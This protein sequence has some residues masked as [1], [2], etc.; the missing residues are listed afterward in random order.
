MYLPRARHFQNGLA[1]LCG[2]VLAVDTNGD[3]LSACD[4][5]LMVIADVAGSNGPLHQRPPRRQADPVP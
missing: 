1:N 5:S 2:D 3:F 4:I